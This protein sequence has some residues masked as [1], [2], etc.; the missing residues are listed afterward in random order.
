MSKQIKEARPVY[1]IDCDHMTDKESMHDELERSLPL[2]SYYGRNLDAL[3]DSLWELGD[4]TIVIKGAGAFNI[5]GVYGANFLRTMTD[6]RDEIGLDVR[7]LS[8]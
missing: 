1:V 3:W 5:C 4:C 2:P 6:A 8:D 7:I